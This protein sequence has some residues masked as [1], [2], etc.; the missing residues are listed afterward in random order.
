VFTA[1]RVL[2]GAVLGLGVDEAYTLSVAHDFQLSYYDHPPLQYWIAHF[3]MPLLGD[4]RAAR[5]PFIGLFAV[6][7]WLLYR[8]TQ[9]LFG[10]NAAVIAVLALNCSA[11]F[12]FAGG[13]VLPDGPLMLALLAATLTLARQLFAAGAPRTFALGGWLAAGFW[14]GVAALSKYH[15]VLFALG[16]LVF[17]VSVPDR[18]AE[19]RRPSMWLGALLAL[20]VAT[21]VILWNGQHDWISIVYQA[22][23]GRFSGVHPGYLLANILGQAIWMLPWIFVPML[24]ASWRAWQAGR[25][26]QR[27]WF[28]LCLSFPTIAVFTLIPLWG[29][30]GLPHWQMSGWLML[31][32]VLGEHLGRSLAPGRL[33]RWSIVSA[34]L[35]ALIAGVLTAHAVSGAGRLLAPRLFAHGDPTL[36]AFEWRQ[37][38]AEL[39][40]RVFLRP[41]T[42]IITTNWR[43]AGRIDLAFHDA[44]PVVVFGANPKQFGLRYDPARL[45][46]HD[47]LLIEPADDTSDVASR[48][49]A[50][51][52]SVQEL[53]SFALG[54]SGLQEIPLRL[55]WARCLLEPLPS[56][57]RPPASALPSPPACLGRVLG[58]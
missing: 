56:P 57:Y 14:L 10:A 48:L 17:L 46:G 54:R 38:P 36:D 12:G 22:S 27:S 9:L 49:A 33:R 42:F 26:A 58:D 5:L 51:F 45:V 19:L 13:W 31:Y 20:G 37:L 2:L 41:G 55:T 8:L 28:C 3:F 32:P 6:S 15:A 34:C 53:R 40:G 21:P 25:R 35:I 18:R 24:S 1:G 16:M 50:Y 47:A 44:F 7:C 52:V 23:R 39:Q 11:F 30:L 43:Y 4:G 29:S